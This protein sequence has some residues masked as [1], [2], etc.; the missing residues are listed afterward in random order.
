VKH[1]AGSKRGNQRLALPTESIQSVWVF[2]NAGIVAG[3]LVKIVS[4]IGI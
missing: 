3:I 4:S 2:V 1:V